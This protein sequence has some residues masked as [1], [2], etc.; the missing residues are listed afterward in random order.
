MAAGCRRGLRLRRPGA[1]VGGLPG[2]RV[3]S[4]PPA[5]ARGAGEGSF[6]GVQLCSMPHPLPRHQPSAG[7][8]AGWSPPHH[9]HPP[10]HACPPSPRQKCV[11][12]LAEADPATASTRSVRSGDW[13]IRCGILET[14]G[15]Q[16]L[17]ELRFL[18]RA[19]PAAR[20]APSLL[21]CW[22]DGFL[23]RPSGLALLGASCAPLWSQL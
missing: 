1:R 23:W 5:G 2:A 21:A 19:G 7:S 11:H 12:T 17:Q 3:A 18:A 14:A 16:G 6:C 10:V 9:H 20:R 13:F 22:I 15:L 8:T 4:P